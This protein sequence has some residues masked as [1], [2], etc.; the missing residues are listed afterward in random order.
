M[1]NKNDNKPQVTN[2]GAVMND[3]M[4]GAYSIMQDLDSRTRI[5]PNIAVMNEHNLFKGFVFFKV[6]NAMDATFFGGK[7]IVNLPCKPDIDG[8]VRSLSGD[9][10]G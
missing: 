1:E 2:K 9:D 5:N 8:F 3:I 10:Y 6:C 4:S 7:M